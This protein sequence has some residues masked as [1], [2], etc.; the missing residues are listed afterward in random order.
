MANKTPLTFDEICRAFGDSNYSRG[1]VILYMIAN[2]INEARKKHIWPE[3]AFGPY[4]ALGVIG[5]EYEEL[6]QAVEKETQERQLDEALDV[7]ATACRFVN[8][9]HML[10][11]L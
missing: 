8:E 5:S 7:I 2:R 9:E 11:V 6:V 4:Q 1:V 10:P 3:E